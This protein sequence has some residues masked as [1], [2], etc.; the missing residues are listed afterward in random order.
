[1]AYLQKNNAPHMSYLSNKMFLLFKALLIEKNIVIQEIG[2]WSFL[3]FLTIFIK[4]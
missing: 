4:Y 2:V 3:I 1:M